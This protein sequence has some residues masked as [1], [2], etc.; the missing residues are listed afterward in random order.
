MLTASG[1][2]CAWSDPSSDLVSPLAG[3]H[4]LSCR[5]NPLIIPVI[6]DLSHPF[7]HTQAVLISF[8][9]Q[10]VAISGVALR[11]FH[12]FDPITVS[13][14]QR[15]QTYSPAEQRW[16]AGPRPRPHPPP[17]TGQ[18]GQGGTEPEPCWP[19]CAAAEKLALFLLSR[20]DG[21]FNPY[22]IPLVNYFLFLSPP[23][24]ILRLELGPV[25]TLCIPP[26]A[27]AHTSARIWPALCCWSAGG[28]SHGSVRAGTKWCPASCLVLSPALPA[29][30]CSHGCGSALRTSPD[31]SRVL[32]SSVGPP[33]MK[34]LWLPFYSCCY[35]RHIN[36][37][38]PTPLG[39]CFTASHRDA[40][41]W[42]PLV[43]QLCGAFQRSGEKKRGEF[44]KTPERIIFFFLLWI[45]SCE[46]SS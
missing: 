44:S 46:R 29:L 6:H 39:L 36:R 10:F 26:L 45:P 37:S 2:D 23:S 41:L 20:M 35:C 5:N 27:A 31:P 1:S 28:T 4:V 8:S 14:C 24:F 3:V 42:W 30:R 7:Y 33:R 34:G 38:P 17:H 22:R 12:N 15:G 32:K 43:R 21:T 25:N 9:S 40:D 19:L 11:S 13:S 16:A 18:G